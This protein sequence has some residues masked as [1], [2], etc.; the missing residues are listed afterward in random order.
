M[1]LS[2]RRCGALLFCLLIATAARGQVPEFPDST[3]RQQAIARAER[4]DATHTTS[5]TTDYR[6]LQG[7]T[8]GIFRSYLTSSTTLLGIPST[9]DQ[10]DALIDMEY[11][12]SS[13]FRVFMLS[14]GT[15]TN[16]ASRDARIAGLNNTAA[17]FLGLGG[18]I[19]DEDGNRLGI[20]AGGA[21]NRQLNVEDGGVGL[22]GEGSGSLDLE[23]Y[24]IAA[25]G[26]GR[27]YNVAPRH[28]SNGD[29]D[30]H[31]ARQFDEGSVIDLQG[32][33]ELINTDLLVK[34][35]EDD[36]LRY[37]GLTY[38]ALQKRGEGRLRI[39]SLI[40]YPVNDELGIDATVSL[41]RLKIDQ[42]EQNDGLPGLP[43]DPDPYGFG[44]NELAIGAVIGGH[45][46]PSHLRVN[47][48]MEYYTSEQDNT[49]ERIGSVS[50]VELEQ[51]RSTSAQN[52]FVSQQIRLAG[53][54]EYRPARY[55]TI[56]LGGSVG[57][58]RYD[59]PSPTN[60]FDK[61]EQTIQGELRYSRSFS[62]MLDLSVYGQIFL[63]H[64]VYLFGQNSNDNNWNRVFRIAPS[65]GYRIGEGFQNYL[66]TEVVANYTVYDF[67]GRTQNIRGRSFRELH[68]RDS[69]GLSISRTLRLLA[70]GDLRIAERGSFSW[71]QFAESPLE[72]TRTEGLEAE[73]TTSAIEGTTFGI[74]G[75]LSRV[76]SYRT[77]PRSIALL[78]YSDR[79]SVGPTARFEAYLSERTLVRFT[80][81]WEHRFDES[82]LVSR[83]PI[84]FMTA[85]V[86]F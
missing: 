12:T 79:T 36:I 57:I 50:D 9:R 10:V 29:L 32:H 33:Y 17:G 30:L 81:W 24:H 6:L 34:R 75:R 11:R 21:Y 1:G 45:W 20:A 42:R 62:P 71:D 63:T 23:G 47:A 69:L 60:Y 18:R 64:L 73:L 43:R 52:D 66:E 35:S 19:V 68:L 51:K 58:Y 53:S 82:R 70:S 72:R 78:P 31:I 37:G 85:G 7:A 83:L 49:V 28:N 56:S 27:F 14:E 55:D 80:G 40:S 15:L 65:V 86:R 3:I 8:A 22:Y 44:R 54:A 2:N 77:D 74:G 16:D 76:K 4:F 67:E 39:N 61:D 5:L 26:V 84:L 48:R 46:N 13:P 41:S 38:E 59:T 25:Q